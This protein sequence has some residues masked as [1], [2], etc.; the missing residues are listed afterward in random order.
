M[1]ESMTQLTN[2]LWANTVHTED[3]MRH[4]ALER[5]RFSTKREERIQSRAFAWEEILYPSLQAES[6]QRIK[7]DA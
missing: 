6:E 1:T 2:N 3:A 7:P 4:E 5:E